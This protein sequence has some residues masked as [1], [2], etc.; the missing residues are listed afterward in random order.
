M[1]SIIFLEQVFNLRQWT[2]FVKKKYKRQQCFMLVIEKKPRNLFC[3]G[4]QH[5]AKIV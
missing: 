4:A 1:T 2:V 5:A 3:P